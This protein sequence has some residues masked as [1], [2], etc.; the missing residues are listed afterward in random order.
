MRNAETRAVNSAR[1]T[2]LTAVGLAGGLGADA[3]LGI[4]LG[5][6]LNAMVVISLMTG[7]IG[8]LLGTMQA[9]GLRRVLA[10][11]SRWVATTI[12]GAMIGLALAVVIVQELG[13]LITGAPLHVAKAGTVTRAVAF[14]LAGLV[15]GSVLGV[16]QWRAARAKID[17]P[18]LDRGLRRSARRRVLP[19]LA[20]RRRVRHPLRVGR[21]AFVVLAGITFGALTSRPLR[22]AA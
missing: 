17:G 21:F 15:A 11:P 7:V 10:R 5:Q 19:R 6:V 2:M 4:P 8:G 12:A 9:V 13:I 16:A 1:W 18:A 20:A 3:L 14:L 22:S